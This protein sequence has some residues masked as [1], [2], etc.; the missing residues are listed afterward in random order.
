MA[1]YSDIDP[2]PRP[3]RPCVGC[4]QSDQAPRD[5]VALAD[6][7]TAYYHFD[8]HVLI[9][10]CPVC[11]AAL[12]GAGGHGPK[13]KKNADLLEHIVTSQDEIFT[14]D[15]AAGYVRNGGK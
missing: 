7:N 12:A 11:A 15:D 6:G 14:T 10:N 5:Q 2:D 3:I 8:C 4:G 1:E 13:G 9:A